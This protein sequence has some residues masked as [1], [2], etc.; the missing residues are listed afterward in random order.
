VL[1][2]QRNGTRFKLAPGGQ[3]RGRRA[4]ALSRRHSPLC[5][6]KRDHLS[7][8]DLCLK[9]VL[10]HDSFAFAP[11]MA[12]NVVLHT[13]HTQNAGYGA[14][15][16]VIYELKH[17]GYRVSNPCAAVRGF[18][19]HCSPERHYRHVI[20]NVGRPGSAHPNVAVRCTSRE[21]RVW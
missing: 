1:G 2:P 3:D 21:L 13:A 17:A 4:L 9:Y 19:L 15:N 12:E 20:V 7:T 6:S 18:H 14:E 10:S 8:F 16:I 5:G 11:P